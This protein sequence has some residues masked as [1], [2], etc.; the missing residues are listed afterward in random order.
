MVMM[1]RAV[2]LCGMVVPRQQA[3]CFF[4]LVVEALAFTE[5]VDEAKRGTVVPR[6]AICFLSSGVETFDRIIT[7]KQGS[8]RFRILGGKHSNEKVVSDCPPRG[9]DDP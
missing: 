6:K 2:K 5:L 7:P 9:L 1:I 3:I 8:L 4:S